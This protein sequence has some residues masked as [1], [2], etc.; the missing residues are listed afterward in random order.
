MKKIILFAFFAVAMSVSCLN[1]AQWEQQQP[2]A[3]GIVTIVDGS[4]NAPYYVEF[5]NG[6]KASVH[7]N[8]ASA[9][10]TFPTTP[11]VLKG[12][13]RK[14]IEYYDDGEPLEGFDKSIT[15][16]AMASIPT[17]VVKSL[18]DEEVAKI[19]NTYDDPMSITVAGY[20]ANR[21]YVTLVLLFYNSS[22]SNYNHNF[23]LAYNPDRTGMYKEVYDALK[24]DAEAYLWLELYH[25][26]NQDTTMT[27]LDETYFS[28]KLDPKVTGVSNHASYKGIKIIYKNVETKLNEVYTIEFQQ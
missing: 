28:V 27:E 11:E 21:D 23:F 8:R 13:V 10:I 24:P 3:A 2:D 6:S 22:S 4:Y 18:K 26:A 5:D 14:Y 1:T 17:D 16:A 15:I 12:E 19:I 20:A 9:T 7:S 25:D